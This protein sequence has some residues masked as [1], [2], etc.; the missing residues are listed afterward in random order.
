[1]IWSR[2][3]MARIRWMASIVASVPE[4]LKRHKRQAEPAR[5]LACDDDRVVGRLGEVRAL[6]DAALHRLDDVGVGVAGDHHAV[7]AVQID[8]LGAVD[9]PDLASRDRG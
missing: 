7:A 9:V 5:Q 6:R 4:L 2:P 3:V 1:M 8:V